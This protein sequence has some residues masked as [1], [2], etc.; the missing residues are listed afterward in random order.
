[1]AVACDNSQ[2]LS[3][4]D[5]TLCWQSRKIRQTRQRIVEQH[6]VATSRD[7]DR[8]ERA[9][10][11]GHELR[12]EQNEASRQKSRDEMDERN[13]RSIAAAMK[14]AF[15][16]KRASKAHAIEPA[17]KLLATPDFNAMAMSEF[18]QGSV[19]RANA[20][21]DPSV[22]TLRL[23]LCATGDHRLECG[24]DRDSE[25]VGTNGASQS[26][27]DMKVAERNDAALFRLDPEQ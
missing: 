15:A 3:A 13:L 24:I 21:I 9:Q 6:T 5:R 11:F 4:A 2:R 17:C 12:I 7:F 1:M 8:T 19:E 18:M 25:Y 26:G 22:V 14:H 10:V 27:R 23:R 20:A 16:E